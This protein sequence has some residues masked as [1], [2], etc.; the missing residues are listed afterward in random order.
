MDHILS[1]RQREV[2][3]L[4]AQGRSNKEI[5][6]TL[7]ISEF[8]VKEHVGA[9]F[10]KLGVKCRAAAAVTGAWSGTNIFQIMPPRLN[11]SY[12]VRVGF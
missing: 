10:R 1:V 4:I 9:L 11:Y 6:R 12:D 8:T 3:D 5:A 2:L 7:R